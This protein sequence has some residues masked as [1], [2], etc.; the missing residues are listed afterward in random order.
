[1][2]ART[3]QEGTTA[4]RLAVVTVQRV[5]RHQGLLDNLPVSVLVDGVI[6]P[7]LPKLERLVIA[8]THAHPDRNVWRARDS[9][10]Q[11]AF[12][13]FSRSVD[14]QL[15]RML[16]R[17][18]VL[19]YLYPVLFETPR[20][21]P[22]ILYT[23]TTVAVTRREYPEWLGLTRRGWRDAEARE[24]R[25]FR[26]AFA[27]FTEGVSAAESA[28][29]D[30][31]CEPARVVNIGPA[32]AMPTPLEFSTRDDRVRDQVLFVGT[33]FDGRKGGETL[34]EAWPQIED[35]VPTARLH[36]VTHSPPPKSLQPSIEWHRNVESARLGELF[37]E[38]R[39]YV[40][41]APY[42]S[43]VPNSIREAMA[44]G[45]PVVTSQI[46]TFVGELP[47]SVRTFPVGDAGQLA[48]HVIALLSD[49]ETAEREGRTNHLH[50]SASF[51][52]DT[53]AAA[54]AERL[55]D[56]TAMP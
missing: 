12:A 24:Q 8:A 48:R 25:V 55:R 26:D 28:V 5:L 40:H 10:N 3:D 35:A 30:Y 41:P 36:V 23:D 14:T 47:S 31:G 32:P 21:Q 49:R 27:V 37:R 6:R 42:E 33:R 17:P 16:V 46:R 19:L 4:L 45:L 38:S 1:M 52:W 18:D 22:M 56:A 15:G 44:F 9:F 11:S 43:C 39:A 54:L 2:S 13:A 7:R 20:A 50:A 51:R 53:A 29:E 34:L